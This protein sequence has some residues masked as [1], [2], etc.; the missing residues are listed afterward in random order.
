M[1]HEG[2]IGT[3]VFYRIACICSFEDVG[4]TIDW[5]SKK[6]WARHGPVKSHPKAARHLRSQPL[7]VEK[8]AVLQIGAGDVVQN[9]V[10]AD[11]QVLK[12]GVALFPHGLD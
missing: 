8:F 1:P 7:C 6:V 2:D 11:A 4:S 9:I 3:Q 5:A 12:A 10:K